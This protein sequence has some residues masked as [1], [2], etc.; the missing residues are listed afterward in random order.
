MKYHKI[1][2][3][4]TFSFALASCNKDMT[5]LD[6]YFANAKNVPPQQ[7]EPLPEINSPEVFI[8]EALDL[9]DPFS[10]DLQLLSE[11]LEELS[12]VV[13]GQGPDLNRKKEILENYPLDSLYMV[14]TYV[15][16]GSNW[17][18]IEDPEGVIHR[19]SLDEYLGQNYGKVTVINEDQIDV[20]EWVSD[21]LGGWTIRN[22]SIALREQ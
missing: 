20:S 9:R 12:S 11:K 15:Q 17:G 6:R 7:I 3:L 10:N 18:L 5:D 4:L 16:E 8:Y 14:G 19:V 21:G 22:S 2:L 13:E 1:I